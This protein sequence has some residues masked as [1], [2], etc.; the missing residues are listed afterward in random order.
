M[1]ANRTPKIVARLRAAPAPAEPRIDDGRNRIGDERVLRERGLVKIGISRF[2]AANPDRAHTLA[3]QQAIR[4]G[5]EEVR[6][7]PPRPD[8]NSNGP[9]PM[10]TA[11]FYVRLQLPFGAVFRDLTADEHKQ[12]GSGG[13]EISEVIGGTPASAANL[14]PG[15]FV[16]K[17][18]S[19]NVRDRAG[20]QGL[21]GS[22]LGRNVTLTVRRGSITL[23]RLV[24]LGTLPD[25]AD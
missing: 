2:A 22:H 7:Y 15:D 6:L 20:F 13:V 10:W 8:A 11:D 25:Q 9:T 21:L 16:L 18:D 24:Q 3:Q 23:K 4:H 1:V 14:R 5:A 17:L 19:S 12:L